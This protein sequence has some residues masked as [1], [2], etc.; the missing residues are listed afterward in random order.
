MKDRIKYATLALAEKLQAWDHAMAQNW[1]LWI[2]CE[3][4]HITKRT[5]IP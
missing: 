1:Y 3:L 4:I 2:H 5:Q